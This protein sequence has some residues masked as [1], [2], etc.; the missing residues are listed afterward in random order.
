MVLC[1]EKLFAASNKCRFLADQVLFLGY[2]I[3]GDGIS[4]DESK[5]A[6][7]RDWP[8]PTTIHGLVL[9]LFMKFVASMDWLLSIIDSLLTL[10][11]WLPP[12]VPV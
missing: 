10:V 9:L 5:V 7:I 8:R 6:A 12:L 4:V 2:I 1:S 3:S 11:V